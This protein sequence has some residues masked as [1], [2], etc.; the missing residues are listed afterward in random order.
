MR[1]YFSTTSQ[2]LEMTPKLRYVFL[3]LIPK[4]RKVFNIISCPVI[5]CDYKRGSDW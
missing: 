2:Q 5:E 4:K 3:F 1:L